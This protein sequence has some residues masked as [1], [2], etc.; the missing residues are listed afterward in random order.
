MVLQKEGLNS[1]YTTTTTHVDKKDLEKTNKSKSF[2]Y[3]YDEKRNIVV[4]SKNGTV[5]DII[6]IN[7]LFIGLPK[8]P[9]NIYSRS[10]LKKEQYW[11]AKEY[12]K[13]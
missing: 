10:S 4:I 13:S 3:G 12:P 2:K 9:K 6:H 7:G 1:L 11:E 8:Q 5:G